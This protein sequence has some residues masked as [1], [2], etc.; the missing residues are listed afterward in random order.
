MASGQDLLDK[1]IKAHGGLNRWRSIKEIVTHIRC[2]GMALP[3]RFKFGTFKSYEAQIST[4]KPR[5]I[6]S[7]FAGK[8]NRGIFLGDTV[9]I[10]TDNGQVL[11]ERTNAKAAFNNFRH[12]FY[13]DNLDAL[14]FGGYAIWNYFSA[15][16]LFLHKGFEIQEIDPWE[17]NNHTWRRLQ[18]FFPSDIPT[19]SREQVFYFNS[20][21]LL[22]RLDYTAEVFGEWAK[23]AHYCRGHKNFSGLIL[24][25]SRQVLPR[26]NEGSP[27]SFPTLVWIEVDQVALLK[28]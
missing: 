23:A 28:G 13:W 14:Y 16:F 27:R 6:F 12:K 10:E 11:A 2:G 7:P 21:G 3:L 22:M 24:P 18:V 1:A 17:E 9:R 25:T 8:G 20:E 26:K 5:I 4:T 19:H 15:P